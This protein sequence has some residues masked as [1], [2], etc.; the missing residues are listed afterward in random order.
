MSWRGGINFNPASSLSAPAALRNVGKKIWSVRVSAGETKCSGLCFPK[1]TAAFSLDGMWDNKPAD[2]REERAP[3][4]ESPA[5]HYGMKGKAEISP[6]TW[7]RFHKVAR[8]STGGEKNP[9]NHHL[10][11]CFHFGILFF[12]ILNSPF[13]NSR[14]DRTKVAEEVAAVCW[15]NALS[16]SFHDNFPSKSWFGDFFFPPASIQVEM[17]SQMPPRLCEKG[18]HQMQK[19]QNPWQVRVGWQRRSK[20]TLEIQTW[21]CQIFPDK[22]T[23]Q[24]FSHFPKELLPSFSPSCLSKPSELFCISISTDLF[25]FECVKKTPWAG[26]RGDT[27]CIYSFQLLDFFYK[28]ITFLGSVASPQVSLPATFPSPQSLLRFLTSHLW[29]AFLRDHFLLFPSIPGLKSW[30]LA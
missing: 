9:H 27:G 12:K 7:H 6:F 5:L 10:L 26:V 11:Y 17:A 24:C 8:K 14:E 22:A 20:T 23:S 25:P 30:I 16:V 1:G 21:C 3:G 15:S 18:K 19:K 29:D 2:Q 4:R 28:K 13:L